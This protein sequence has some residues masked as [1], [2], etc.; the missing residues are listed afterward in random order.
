MFVCALEIPSLD[1]NVVSLGKAAGIVLERP[2]KPILKASSPRP[3]ITY[4]VIAASIKTRTSRRVPCTRLTFSL[5]GVCPRPSGTASGCVEGV[6]PP[7]RSR[8]RTRHGVR[9][10]NSVT[11]RSC[12]TWKANR[13]RCGA[14]TRRDTP[15]QAR[16]VW[17]KKRDRP[18]NGRCRLHGG[19]STG[20]RTEEGR[21]RS[22]EAL[23]RGHVNW[24][25]RQ[26]MK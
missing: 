18:L 22:L 20:P 5:S 15:C 26:G 24:A 3:S 8:A 6:G 11:R 23:K 7:V 9:G 21:R 12:T 16:A 13:P 17:D 14:R 10:A 25:E 19:L 4:S 1:E 2:P